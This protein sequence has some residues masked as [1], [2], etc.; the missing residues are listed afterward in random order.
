[1]PPACLCPDACP[2]VLHHLPVDAPYAGLSTAAAAAAAVACGQGPAWH[3]LPHP[4]S[5]LLD[6]NAAVHQ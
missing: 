4:S 3:L 2:Y 5:W 1:M 6:V